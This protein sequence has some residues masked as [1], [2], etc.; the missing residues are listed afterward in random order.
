[1]HD[2][3]FLFWNFSC[4]AVKARRKKTSSI[5]IRRAF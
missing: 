5:S 2:L 1:M 4:V 3:E